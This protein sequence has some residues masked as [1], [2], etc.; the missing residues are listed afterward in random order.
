MMNARFPNDCAPK[1]GRPSVGAR[2]RPDGGVALVTTVIVV[3]MLAV[4]AVALMQS[5]TAD[6]ASSRSVANYTRAQLAAEAGLAEAM[7]LIQSNAA[8]FSYVSGAEPQAGGYRTYIRPRSVVGGAWQFSGPT[9]YLDSGT[10]GSNATLLVSGTSTNDGIVVR[11]SYT[12]LTTNNFSTNRYAFWVDDGSGKQNLSWWGASGASRGLLAD[13]TNAAL[14]LPSANGTTAAAMPSS[15][16]SQLNGIRSHTTG[17]T[18]LFGQPTPFRSVSNGLLT[19]ATFNLLDPGLQGRASRYFFT[20]SSPSS[21]ASPAG[22]RK[23]NLAQLARYLNSGI[24]SAQ[25]ATSPKALLLEDLLKANPPNQINWGGGDLNWLATAGKYSA[26]EQRQIVA[27][28]LDYLDDDMVPTTDSDT[29]PSYFG[30]EMKRDSSG[31]VMGHPVINFVT[32]GLIFNRSV[33]GEVNSTRVLC[34]LGLAFPW[35]SAGVSAAAYQP[36]INIRIEGTMQNG[37]PGLGS[38]A[39]PYFRT[40]DLSDQISSR[41]ITAFSPRSGNNWPQSVGLAGTASYATPFYG[42]TTGN[43]SARGPTNMTLQ[44]GR[45]VITKLRL[46]YT[47]T[48]GGAGGYVQV[49]PTNMTIAVEPANILLGGAGPLSLIVKF[50]E[51][52]PYANTANLYMNSDPRANFRPTSW[53]NLPSVTSFS[54]SIPAPAAGVSALTLTNGAD[55]EWDEAQGLTMNFNW[56]SAGAITNHLTR[57]ASTNCDSIGEIGYIWTGK[58]WQT[59]NLI[60]TNNANTADHN[61]LDYL[62][63]GFTNGPAAYA[64]MPFLAPTATGSNVTTTNSLLQDGGFNVLTRKLA[65]AT[66]YL[67]NA[68]GLSS[69][70]AADFAAL[71]RPALPSLGGALA[72]M[73]NLSSVT[74][75]KFG[76]EAIVRATA[77]GAVTQSRLFTVYARGEYISSGARSQALLEADVFVD[78][79]PTTGSPRLKV[80]SKKFL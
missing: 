5:T 29:S 33:A 71:P 9:V 18:N 15:A 32:A 53:T 17:T 50:T 11:A 19:P 49:L 67:T 45:F 44:N 79:D 7:A 68:P 22:R 62:A 12:N 4:V 25:G 3:A 73:S 70:A 21:A 47:P 30:V 55:P 52:G 37:V 72:V 48:G 8:N 16:L 41:P 28:L 65:T 57:F 75:T 27:N 31:L 58:P 60:R 59:L 35:S 40:N 46:R 23:L 20:L 2:P 56:F 43:W 26:T 39:T 78:V 64:T 6:R 42:F 80:L 63:G 77:N 13:I 76:R 61:L 74:T 14:V 36:E 66:S 38:Q 69:S 54:T 1:N 24:S 51:A 10:G 34:S